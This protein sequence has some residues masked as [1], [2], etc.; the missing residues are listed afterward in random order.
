LTPHRYDGV[1]ET[2]HERLVNWSEWIIVRQSYGHCRSIE[3]RY[4]PER[5]SDNEERRQELTRIII[6][7]DDAATV[8]RA[9][10]GWTFPRK[11]RSILRCHYVA[12]LRREQCCRANGIRLAQFSFELGRAAMILSNR[13]KFA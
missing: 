10:T 6:D 2:I 5:I 4:V 1:D 11:P 3:W 9:I 13:L 7:V 8:E 12:R